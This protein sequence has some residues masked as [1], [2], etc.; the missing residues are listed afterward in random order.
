MTVALILGL[1]LALV[2]ALAAGAVVLDVHYGTSGHDAW[3]RPDL[4]LRRVLRDFVAGPEVLPDSDWALHLGPAFAEPGRVSREKNRIETASRAVADLKARLSVLT[5]ASRG[6]EGPA[7]DIESELRRR[8]EDAVRLLEAVLDERDT[9]AARLTVVLFGRTKAGKSSL[10]AALTGDGFEGI[11]N[12]RQN[13]TTEVQ[14]KV[15]G[16]VELIDSPGINGVGSA[17]LELATERA[18]Y[19]ADVL[20]VQVTDDAV[21]LEDFE[22]LAALGDHDRPVV[23]T[24]NVKKGDTDLLVSRPEKV[25]R[26]KRVE[27][28]VQRLRTGLPPKW[29]DAPVVVYH[30]LG[31]V[32]ARTARRRVAPTMWSASRITAVIQ[33]IADQAPSAIEYAERAPDEALR[34][35]I[36]GLVTHEEH[37]AAEV[38]AFIGRSEGELHEIKAIL[39]EVWSSKNTV[40]REIDDHF[41]AAEGQILQAITDTAEDYAITVR[42]ALA[43]QRL[44]DLLQDRLNAAAQELKDKYEEFRADVRLAARISLDTEELDAMHAAYQEHLRALDEHGRK[45]KRRRI[46]RIGSHAAFGLATVLAAEMPPLA[47]AIA[48]AGARVDQALGDPAKPADDD[49]EARQRRVRSLLDNATE[50]ARTDYT[51]ALADQVIAPGEERLVVPMQRKID[52]LVDLTGSIEEAL[53]AERRILDA[54]ETRLAGHTQEER[55]VASG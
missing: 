48:E 34:E 37:V 38:R 1:V 21:N 2:L 32:T 19:G 23:V 30:A 36:T 4:A 28:Y 17:A 29:A 55:T 8:R 35:V 12:G 24:V 20:V 11:G 50:T 5:G 6:A 46:M 40:Y 25:F 10:F 39:R 52:R 49:P 15:V 44:V 16:E 22:R 53:I 7:V 26:P 33:A 54:A 9:A 43:E 3:R 14:T 27:P 51:K 45:V 42:S 31:A 13:Y 47:A 41:V 18:V